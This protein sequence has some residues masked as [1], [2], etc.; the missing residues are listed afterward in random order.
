MM[1]SERTILAALPPDV[2]KSPEELD[3]NTKMEPAAD[4][5]E[6]VNANWVEKTDEPF[7]IWLARTMFWAVVLRAL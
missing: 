2:T 6:L 7:M 4:V 3:V 1:M 5:G